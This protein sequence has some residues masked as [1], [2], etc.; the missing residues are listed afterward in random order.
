MRLFDWLNFQHVVAYFFP[1][2]IFIVVFGV[3][4]GYRHIYAKDAEARKRTVIH[5]YPDGLKTRDAPFPLIMVLLIC[6]VVIWGF[7]Y[8]LATGLLGVG[9]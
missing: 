9:I 6:G 7:S 1:T 3:G 5:A 2:L 8:I 4:L